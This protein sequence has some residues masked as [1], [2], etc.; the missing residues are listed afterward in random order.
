MY[1]GANV[2]VEWDDDKTREDAYISLVGYNEE[3][4]CDNAGIPDDR[5][6]FYAKS[7]E[8]LTNMRFKGYAP[9][10]LITYELVD[11]KKP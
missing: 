2:T 3:T 11:D 1:I 6:I 9:F 10:R 4:Q 8:D 7:V 5:I